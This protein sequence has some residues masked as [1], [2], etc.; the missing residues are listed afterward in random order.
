MKQIKT[1]PNQR[2]ISI[3]KSPTDKQ[4][5][6]TKNSLEGLS[7]AASALTSL[8]GFKLYMYLSM[9]QNNYSFALSSADFIAWANVSR[10]A[11]NTAFNELLTKGYLVQLNTSNY[12]FYDIAQNKQE[13]REAKTLP[14]SSQNN[15]FCF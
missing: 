11:Y 6:Y 2:I 7:Q 1:V 4:H 9:N 8:A 13:E 14:N 5:L 10:T 12:A 15:E 3:N